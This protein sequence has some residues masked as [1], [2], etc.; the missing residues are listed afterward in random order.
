MIRSSSPPS[1]FPGRHY[2]S[3]N[4]RESRRGTLDK[5]AC[6]IFTADLETRLFLTVSLETS[7]PVQRAERRILATGNLYADV[8]VQS[9]TIQ[10]TLQIT[11]TKSDCLL[12]FLA[13][14]YA[15]EKSRYVTLTIQ[16]FGP[17]ATPPR[18]STVR[19]GTS[20]SGTSLESNTSR[21]VRE[22]S[23]NVV[24]SI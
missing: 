4:G 10:P 20:P 23:V 1:P 17:S 19:S 21:A 7:R 5:M 6:T 11:R 9:Q 3:S 12:V 16:T 8:F 2:I 14:S 18:P 15:W 22:R 24:H 13:R